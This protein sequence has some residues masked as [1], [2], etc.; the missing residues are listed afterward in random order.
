MDEIPEEAIEEA[1][2][3]KPFHSHENVFSE[4]DSLMEHLRS[5]HQLDVEPQLSATTQEG[6]HDRLHHESNAIDD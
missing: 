4:N 6:L 3:V 5:V 2:G 1:E